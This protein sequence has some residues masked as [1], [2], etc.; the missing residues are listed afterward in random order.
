MF[1]CELVAPGSE[2]LI[3]SWRQHGHAMA[4]RGHAGKKIVR[5]DRD[6][7]APLVRWADPDAE[8]LQRHSAA[9]KSPAPLNPTSIDA[10][11]ISRTRV[12][13]ATAPSAIETWESA[14]LSANR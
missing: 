13:A 5:E 12:S 3:G 1:G 2:D 10:Y 11:Q 9:R 6:P 7:S 14:T 8:N 4:Q